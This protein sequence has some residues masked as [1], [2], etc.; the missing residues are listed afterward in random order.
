MEPDDC[1]E[2]WPDTK[3]DEKSE[4]PQPPSAYTPQ[5][6]V[7]WTN[8]KSKCRAVERGREG[9]STCMQ[10]RR[11]GGDVVQR[12]GRAPGPLFPRPTVPVRKLTCALTATAVHAR[13]ARAAMRKRDIVR[14]ELN[15]ME[16]CDAEQTA[17]ALA[18]EVRGKDVSQRKSNGRIQAHQHVYMLYK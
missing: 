18:G 1:E 3:V 14:D 6:P 10:H 12:S 9:E 5:V 13:M 2:H 16:L 7:P 4:M 17:G 8:G 11:A 15:E